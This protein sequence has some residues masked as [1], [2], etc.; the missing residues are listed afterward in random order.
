MNKVS[1]SIF[2]MYRDKFESKSN[3]LVT[4]N[5]YGFEAPQKFLLARKSVNEKYL[6]DF[7][8]DFNLRFRS[9]IT[10]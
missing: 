7:D 1:Q 4:L 3:E 2:Q 5:G 6:I 8:C 10:I 9:F